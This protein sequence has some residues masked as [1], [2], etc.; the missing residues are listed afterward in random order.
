MPELIPILILMILRLREF[1]EVGK[2]QAALNV[3]YNVIKHRNHRTWQKIHEPIMLKFLELCVDLRKSHLAKEGLY[4]YQN[5]CQQVNIKSLED[6]VRTYLKL[7]EEKTKTPKEESQKMANIVDLDN[8]QTPESVLLSAVSG[9]DTQDRTDHFA[10]HSLSE[11][12]VGVLSPVSGPAEEQL[13]SGAS[14]P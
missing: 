7:A 12:L 14:L 5:I 13:Q 2:K 6:V 4:Q 1:L 8:I 9:E 10:A 3:L 11:I